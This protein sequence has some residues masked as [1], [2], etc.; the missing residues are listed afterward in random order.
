MIDVARMGMELND[1]LDLPGRV[2]L[3]RWGEDAGFDAAYV[4]EITDPDAFVPV[5]RIATVVGIVRDAAEAAGRGG[6]T[7]PSVCA[8]DK[9][10]L[11]ASLGA[12]AR[13]KV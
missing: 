12:F 13:G 11:D 3:A 10:R 9:G 2:A 1:W 5:D 8:L 7:S 4:A 6:V